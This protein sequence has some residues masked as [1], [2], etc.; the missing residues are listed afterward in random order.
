MKNI[1][2]FK[3]LNRTIDSGAQTI[4]CFVTG[5]IDSH[6]HL[7]IFDNSSP[8]KFYNFKTKSFVN[9]FNSQN[10]LNIVLG[11]NTF[12]FTIKIPAS[13]AGNSYTFL[14]IPNYHFETQIQNGTIGLLTQKIEQEKD[15]TVRFST[16]SDQADTN[17]VGIGAFIG[18][19]NGSSNSN[20][21]QTV[22]ISEDL[23]DSGDGLG[24]GYKYSFDI[25]GFGGAST[26]RRAFLADSLQ[27]VDTDFFTKLTKETNGSGSSVTSM[28]LNDVDN[29][30]VG[31]SLVDIESS[32]VTTS[33]S[34]GVLTY[35]TITAI[36]TQ[37]K[38][39]TLSSTH[40]W[41]D[42]KDITFRAYGSELIDESVGLVVS[43]NLSVTPTG[44][45]GTSNFGGG[46]VTVNGDQS[47]TSINIDGIR[48]VS[49]GS[50]I[51]GPG[52]DVTNNTVTAV[53]ASG[54]P[55]TLAGTQ[56]LADNTILTVYGSSINANIKGVMTISRFP[57]IST[58]V[59][60]DIDRAFILATNS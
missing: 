5:D 11:S 30:V 20:S 59:F 32:S 38:T 46:S 41:A 58:D 60:Y 50:K 18:S 13:S 19:T 56:T 47:S 26:P 40:S 25:T 6:C 35:P 49:V 31:M 4:E 33:G 2:S 27:P 7:H 43:F 21:S 12:N 39:V 23:A 48:G 45:L 9:G 29:L 14:L 54:S 57:S 8:T 17:F 34:L 44:F 52:I 51:F 36:N 1:N 42:A 37:T 15:V 16:S 22:N 53:H 10:N 55:I 28:I 24:L 3:I